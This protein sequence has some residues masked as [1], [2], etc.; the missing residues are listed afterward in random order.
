MS[1]IPEN[2][3]INNTE[4]AVDEESVLNTSETPVEEEFST[5]F[6]DPAVHRRTAPEKK[7]G[8][9]LKILAGVL[10]VAVLGTGTW[11]VIEFIPE[12]EED[13]SSPYLEEIT[14]KEIKSD[15]FK[16][17]TVKNDN[18]ITDFYSVT[19]KATDSS[20]S[21]DTSSST[22]EVTKWYIKGV[23][24]S[25]TSDSSIATFIGQFGNVTAVRE[26]TEMTLADC[27]LDKPTLTASAVC[28]DGTEYTLDIGKV[29]DN[30]T[31]ACYG[32]F[33]DS[34]KIYLLTGGYVDSLAEVEP[35]LY[36]A[37]V[38]TPA[39]EVPDGGEDY[40]AEDGSLVS[41][42]K[43]TVSGKNLSDE[44][45][46]EANANKEI[47]NMVGYV[48]TSPS[49][50]IAQN[51]EYVLAIFKSGLSVD[52]AY[53]FDVSEK[54]L[55][56][57]GLD[58]PD[59]MATLEVAGKTMTYKFKLQKDGNCAVIADGAKVISKVSV[60]TD[61][62]GE[63]KVLLSNLLEYTV[64][65]FY[66]FWISLY[67]I[68]DISDFNVNVEGKDYNFAIKAN[69]DEESE[70]NYIIKLNGKKID[71]QSFQY[72]YQWFIT[73]NCSD[74]N[75]DDLDSNPEMTVKFS[76]NKKNYKDSV[77]EFRRSGASRYQYKVDG[78]DMGKTTSAEVNKFVKYLK[79]VADGEI[80]SEIA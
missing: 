57:F 62:S 40:I 23:D 34:D 71:C 13:V 75:V 9:L 25:Y 63:G 47:A 36:D 21:S 70:D 60:T 66:A 79:K 42:D 69:E 24:K 41:F 49:M 56:K 7:K 15:D 65:D 77:I 76:F 31:G 4:T 59:F 35:L 27:G 33:S 30:I 5:I 54:A 1:N 39:F 37:T 44:V 43:L 20:D 50:R 74:F 14:V 78:I 22:A 68:A 17:V 51:A 10:A 72:L 8:Y 3:K 73:M 28:K 61:L 48:V 38:S 80:I 29:G 19:E 45:V 46:F 52:G 26:I 6:S 18:G 58:K 16:T 55:K 11:A 32:K 12:M 64:T 67:N 2:E 53:A